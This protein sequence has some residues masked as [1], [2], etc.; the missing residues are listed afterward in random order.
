MLESIQNIISRSR[1]F[2]RFEATIYAMTLHK[3]QVN[4]IDLL[5]SG[6]L[7]AFLKE[8]A[9][10]AVVESF[11]SWPSSKDYSKISLSQGKSHF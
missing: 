10:F 2:V 7:I 11:M 6:S 1:F 3:M 9:Q 4:E 8:R 5:F